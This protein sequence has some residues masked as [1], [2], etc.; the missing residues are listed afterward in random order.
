MIEDSGEYD[1]DFVAYDNYLI[2]D[3][4][5]IVGDMGSSLPMIDHPQGWTK[6]KREAP[7]GN[8]IT[9]WMPGSVDELETLIL[10]GRIRVHVNPALRSA[11]AVGAATARDD[12]DGG[13]IDDYFSALLE[14]K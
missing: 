5:A 11:V 3:F 4:E 13:K 6:R 7:D 8:E 1:L 14:S 2:A 12:G 10:E 9:L